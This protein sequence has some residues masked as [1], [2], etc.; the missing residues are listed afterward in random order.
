MR[1]LKRDFISFLWAEFI[2]RDTY[3][4]MQTYLVSRYSRSIIILHRLA[5]VSKFLFEM[6]GSCWVMQY[7]RFLI[8]VRTKKRVLSTFNDKRT[9]IPSCQIQKIISEIHLRHKPP[10]ST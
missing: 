10:H 6:V 8:H 1:T 4:C 7:Y 2:G 9:S 5:E 3:V